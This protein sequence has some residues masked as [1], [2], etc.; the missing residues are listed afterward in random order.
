MLKILAQT[1]AL[2]PSDLPNILR[3]EAV[4]CAVGRL[5]RSLATHGGVDFNGFL[6][7]V[8]S[9]LGQGVPLHRILKRRVAWLIGQ[10]VGSDEESAKLDLVWQI[11]LHLLA[12]RGESSDLAV[13]LTAVTS[14]KECVDLWELDISYFLPYLQ[15]TVE[16][17]VKLLGEA[18]TLD[19][20]RYVNDA[21]GV[22]IERV[23]DKI[24]PYLPTL[25]QAIPGLWH[26]AS[27]LEGEWLFKASLVVLTTKIVTAAKESSGNFMEL[28]I[29]LIEESLQ[30]PAKDFFEEDGIILWQTALH[31][32]AS[33]YQPTHETGLIRLLPGLLHAISENM[34]LLSKLLPLLDSYLLLDAAGIVSSYGSPMCAALMQ[35]ITTSG[36]NAQNVNRILATVSLLVHI[37]PLQQLAGLLLES[38]LFSHILVALE[39]DKASGT[40]LASYLHILARIA[41]RDPTIFLQLV[42][43]QAR[44]SHRDG[45]KLLEE[46]FDAMWRNFDYVGEA[47]A[48]KAVAMGAGALLTTGHQQALERLDGEF[49]NMFLDVLGE[50][51]P[52]D[53]PSGP[54]AS[55]NHWK[56][57]HPVA[58]GEIEHAPEGVRRKTLEDADPAYAVPLRA[59]VVDVLTRAQGVGLGPYWDKADAGAKNSLQKFLA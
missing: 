23:E 26:G 15:K 38:G 34:D 52:A 46:V 56:D 19:G 54:E 24:L 58:W 12:E 53:T 22:V 36:K 47:R 51:Q 3:K 44:I 49:L 40:I 29:P 32:G 50:L 35:A 13:N 9:W 28:V 48:R 11:L 20:K 1:E 18:T 59:Y 30:P 31:N 55:V 10:W 5:S 43:E 33:P 25:A 45:H 16:E 8:G 27:G 37:G 21:I 6:N 2:P 4:Y 39:D 7:G 42:A 17:L 41:M 57:D 14:I